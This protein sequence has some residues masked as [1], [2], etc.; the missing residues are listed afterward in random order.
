[1]NM[2]LNL[3]SFKENIQELNK[4]VQIGNFLIQP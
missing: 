2:T 4:A 3:V 1:M